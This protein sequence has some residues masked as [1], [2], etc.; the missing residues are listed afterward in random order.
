MA[1]NKEY[2]L[3]DT[4]KEVERLQKQ[5]AWVKK[6]MGNKLIFAPVDLSKPDLA[7]LDVGC[8]DGLS[9]HC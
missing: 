2:L 8:A 3:G 4:A 9:P 1:P 5:H 6:S 7:I